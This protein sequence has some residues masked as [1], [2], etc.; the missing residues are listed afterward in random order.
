M[1]VHD[2]CSSQNKNNTVLALKSVYRKDNI[3]TV[4]AL[5]KK[6]NVSDHDTVHPTTEQDFFDWD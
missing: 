4:E 5:F 1:I 2:N 3:Y 6:L